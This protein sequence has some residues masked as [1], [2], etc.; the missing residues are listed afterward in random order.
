VRTSGLHDSC[1]EEG[2]V[3]IGAG[4]ERRE[5]REGRYVVGVGERQDDRRISSR[6]WVILPA[7]AACGMLYGRKELGQNG[8]EQ[9]EDAGA[10]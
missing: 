10:V 6:F 2:N 8:A 1:K 5:R 4:N 7:G 3:P 9:E